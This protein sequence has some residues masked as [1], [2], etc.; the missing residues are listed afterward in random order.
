MKNIIEEME[1]KTKHAKELEMGKKV[2]SR[3]K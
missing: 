2:V 1:N 3:G